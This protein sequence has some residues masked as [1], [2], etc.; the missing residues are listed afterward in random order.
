MDGPVARREARMFVPRSARRVR[1]ARTTFLL[2]I[3]LPSL[4]VVAWAVHRRSAAHREA[5]RVTW[6]QA[7]GLPLAITSVEHPLPGVVRARGCALGAA[8]GA[9]ALAAE[10]VRVETSPAEVRVAIDAL[11]CDPAGAALLAGLA[12]DWL[13]RG[14]R[15]RRDVVIDVADFA[16]SVPGAGGRAERRPLGPV[17]IECVVK[18]GNRAVR[19]VRR[20]A[21]EGADDV[22]IV[23]AAD[24]PGS[25]RLEVEA[26][27]AE[28][29]PGAIL[30]AIVD[31]GGGWPPLG[32][33]ATIRGRL[34]ASVA[35]GA[36]SGSAS[37][38]IEGI[39]LACCTAALA[40]RVAGTLD[41][42][43]RGVEWRGGRLVAADF[44]CDAAAGRVDRRLLESLVST[45]GCRVG[46]AY[47][48]A[49]AENERPFDAAG[50][51]IRV[52]RRGIEI[53]GS[54]RLGGALAVVAGRPV[55]EA[56]AG[57]VSP[58]RVAW[59]LAPS[60]AVYV[61]SSG[62]GSWLMSILP[63]D[64]VAVEHTSRAGND[65]GGGF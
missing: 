61:P 27:C 7:V 11:D 2:A 52:D 13:R 26:S 4:A 17:R 22:R 42:S 30:A 31:P 1:V 58:D 3:L 18:D 59:L 53:A 10:A 55:L 36:S 25:G 50:C 15:F 34:S 5:I 16:W 56:P 20:D 44:A 37:G 51:T 38:L 12:D 21:A 49:S 14:T 63:R 48:G 39:D 8:G 29:V 43:V 47:V 23:H 40:N 46:P 32:R 33:A 6:E 64:G 54:A 65:G 9:S 62:P 35:G 28:P 41:V 57:V 45:L 60:G 24:G 19:I